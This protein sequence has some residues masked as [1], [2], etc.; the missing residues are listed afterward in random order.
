MG[1]KVLLIP[2]L[3]TDI[4]DVLETLDQALT[5]VRREDSARGEPPTV[6]NP[7]VTPLQKTVRNLLRGI[8]P[9]QGSKAKRAR[10]GKIFAPDGKY[11]HVSFRVVVLDGVDIARLRTAA[12]ELQDPRIRAAL[13]DVLRDPPMDHELGTDGVNRVDGLIRRVKCLADLLA[14]ERDTDSDLL[15]SLISAPDRGEDLI[16]T[17]DQEAAYQRTATRINDAWDESDPAYRTTY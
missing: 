13:H 8:S 11:Q 16:L 14:L 17:P 2:D 7:P 5:R 15:T 6:R 3:G 1:A 4:T 9:S 10:L 12:A